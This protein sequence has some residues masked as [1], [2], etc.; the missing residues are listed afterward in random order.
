MFHYR[1]RAG[2]GVQAPALSVC[3]LYSVISYILFY[4]S[5]NG[6]FMWYSYVTVK[7]MH[8]V[9]FEMILFIVK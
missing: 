7:N 3:I 2:V 1:K 4:I 9:E 6:L 5:G 8:C